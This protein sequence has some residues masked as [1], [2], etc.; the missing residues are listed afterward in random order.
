MPTGGEHSHVSLK[1]FNRLC[2]RRTKPSGIPPNVFPRS[3]VSTPPTLC[4]FSDASKS[5]SSHEHVCASDQNAHCFSFQAPWPVRAISDKFHSFCVDP[6]ERAHA[7]DLPPE[8]TIEFEN[9][10]SSTE[11]EELTPSPRPATQRYTCQNAQSYSKRANRRLRAT[12]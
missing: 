10:K 4:T 12:N 5:S 9:S 3:R 1:Y 6:Q 2:K 11:S 8:C 7:E